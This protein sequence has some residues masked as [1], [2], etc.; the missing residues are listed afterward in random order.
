MT[1]LSSI[2]NCWMFSS[3]SASASED[4]SER[5][6]RSDSVVVSDGSE[7]SSSPESYSSEARNGKKWVDM[8]N[9]GSDGVDIGMDRRE[10]ER[11]IRK[12]D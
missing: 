6:S 8:L 3:H 9:E 12:S 5:V 10:Q 7:A 4:S 2:S 1:M 11:W